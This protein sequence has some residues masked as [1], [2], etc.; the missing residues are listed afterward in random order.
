V[1]FA[2]S[3]VLARSCGSFLKGGYVWTFQKTFVHVEE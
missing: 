2:V 3:L 1:F